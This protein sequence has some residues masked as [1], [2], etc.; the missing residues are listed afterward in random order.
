M[1]ITDHQYQRLMNEM[2]QGD[3]VIDHAAMKSGMDRKTA[4]R[5]LRAGQ[6]PADLNKP[7]TWRTRRGPGEGD[8]G[9]GGAS[10]P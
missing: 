8:L 6:G 5:Y 9:R 2:N 1:P 10:A 3:G 4:R 7:H